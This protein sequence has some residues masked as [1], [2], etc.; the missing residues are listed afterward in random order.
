M[1]F[2]IV[3]LATFILGLVALVTG[4][5][6]LTRGMTVHGVPARIIGV[7]DTYG[8]MTEDRVYRKA[9]GHEAAL[10]ELQRLAGKQFDP[11]VVRAFVQLL[12]EN[13][14]LAELEYSHVS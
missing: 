10:N 11:I 3:A 4:K 13:P 2:L 5:V 9:P 8:A 12:A 14:D 7:V 1:C 6:A